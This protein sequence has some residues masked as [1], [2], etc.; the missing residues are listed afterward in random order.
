MLFGA[1]WPRNQPR[2]EAH[3]MQHIAPVPFAD[4]FAARKHSNTDHV[5]VADAFVSVSG[6]LGRDLYL[7]VDFSVMFVLTSSYSRSYI[8]V[9]KMKK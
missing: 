4:R 5:L 8:H 7:C 2:T 6:K 9:R 1:S 3:H